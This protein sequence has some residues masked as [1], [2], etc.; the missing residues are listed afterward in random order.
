MLGT[1]LVARL[2]AA[3]H[4]VLAFDQDDIDITNPTSIERNVKD[5]EVVVNVAAM[6]DPDHIESHETEA[7]DV[8]ALGPHLLARRCAAIGARLVHL[9]THHV[10]DGAQSSPYTE[11]QVASPESGYGRTKIAGEWAVQAGTDNYL[12]V[13]TAWLYGE[14]G[15][16]FP[17]RVID[18][19]QAGEPLD[20]FCGE[21]G[22]PTWTR[23]LADLIMT[24]VEAEVPTGIYH[25]TSQGR[26]TWQD[27]A[28]EICHSLNL[29]V[30]RF[31]PAQATAHR[32]T[33][34][35]FS[36]SKLVELGIEPIGDWRQRWRQA[37][38]VMAP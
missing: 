38:Q 37:A 3:G 36:H 35:V 19:A 23:D 10:F 34:S 27:F 20:V 24:L 29:D 7:F 30:P 33:S 8:N 9:S 13:R 5:V 22:Q 12:I 25:G 2:V 15:P 14:A 18:R 32:P 6:T 11:D 4:S 31:E 28:T 1:D 16:C 17:A 21:V 26:T